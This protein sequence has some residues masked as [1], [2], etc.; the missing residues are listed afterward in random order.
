MRFIALTLALPFGTE[1]DNPLN[2]EGGLSFQ[3]LGH[4]EGEDFFRTIPALL[5]AEKYG[6]DYAKVFFYPRHNWFNLFSGRYFSRGE[7]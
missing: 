6:G 5:P 7:K 2:L 3:K 1:V 4:F